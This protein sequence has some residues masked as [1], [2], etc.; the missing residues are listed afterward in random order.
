MSRIVKK[1]CKVCQDAGKS[2][3]EYTSHFTRESKDP[4]AKVICPL[5]LSLECRFCYKNGHTIKYCPTL[6]QKGKKE[7]K[8]NKANIQ[9]KQ[10][11]SEFKVIN[12]FS[13]LDYNSEEEDNDEVVKEVKE[14]E[15]I[16]Y[17]KVLAKEKPIIQ[18]ESKLVQ[19]VKQEKQPKQEKQINLPKVAPWATGK[20]IFTKSWAAMDSDSEEDEDDEDEEFYEVDF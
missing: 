16:T 7:I 20:P 12:K 11:K 1:Y 5:L 3:E 19:L 17:A 14:E 6:K 18:E 9:E 13:A 4:N 15:K 2:E 8:I 10:Q